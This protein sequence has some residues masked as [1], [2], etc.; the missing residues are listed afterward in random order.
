[1]KPQRDHGRVLYLTQWFTPEPVAIPRWIADALRRRHWDVE[2]ITA[3]PN[4]P[5]GR[6]QDGYDP[7]TYMRELISGY[8]I[9]RAPVYPSRDQSPA[10]RMLTY[11]SWAISCIP[12]TLWRC[13][14]ADVV[15]VYSSPATAALPAMV[16]RVILRKRY[17]LFVQDIW[18]DSVTSSGF[19]GSPLLAKWV[20][21]ALSRFVGLSYR[22]SDA[23]AVIS[24]SAVLELEMRGVPAGKLV[25]VPNW[26]DE[27]V[28]RPRAKKGTLV[29]ELGLSDK[30][31]LLTYA[32]TL[33]PS[34]NLATAISAVSLAPGNVHLALIGDGVA[35]TALR[36]QAED[37]AK[38]RIHFIDP[39]SLHE[40]SELMAEADA[41][42]ISLADDP[43]FHMTMP[44][45][46][47]SVLASGSVVVAAVSGDAAEVLADA[48]AWLAAPG[49]V[50]QLSDAISEVAALRDSDLAAAR[51]RSRAYYEENLSEVVGA[52][53]LSAV[54]ESV[55]TN[56]EIEYCG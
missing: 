38:D 18:P 35:R 4:Y 32:G 37:L 14:R 46:V 50:Q 1:M 23:V 26:A 17:V 47:Q 43:L 2:V 34:Q 52:A 16:A 29:Q 40:A 30:D 19:I 41:Q 45:K 3:H 25:Y 33:G 11:I 24:P 31:F 44:S 5:T 36:A 10:R 53:R 48:G 54:L 22:L 20:A 27:T 8:Q 15:L 12:V 42:L 39:V 49:D 9:S 21:N 28:M 7:R 55:A 51:A 56:R 13:A 6:V